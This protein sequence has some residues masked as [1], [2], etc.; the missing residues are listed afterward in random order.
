MVIMR[1][2]FSP[3]Q[4]REIN[5]LAG[6]WS[7]G[8]GQ[9]APQDPAGHRDPP[10]PSGRM[11]TGLV[12]DSGAEGKKDTEREEMRRL[13]C[14]PRRLGSRRL[15]PGPRS[16]RRRV[17][18]LHGACQPPSN[19]LQSTPVVAA[20]GGGHR[21]RSRA[22]RT[23][24]RDLA[25]SGPRNLL[26]P[27]RGGELDRRAAD[28]MYSASPNAERIYDRWESALRDL[29]VAQVEDL[30]S[31]RQDPWQ[32]FD[33]AASAARHRPDGSVVVHARAGARPAPKARRPAR[34]LR[35]QSRGRR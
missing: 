3:D 33:R 30:R 32:P 19:S 28:V 12:T 27:K 24:R 7:F 9:P 5:H 34:R 1:W 14:N 8:E 25:G 18:F 16:Q 17:G 11:N 26:G 20:S 22:A 15:E 23:P 4:G 29:S 2:P 21:G 6:G 35:A 31:T 13:E 10:S